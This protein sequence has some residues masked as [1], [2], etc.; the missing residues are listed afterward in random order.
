[1]GFIGFAGFHVILHF[2]QGY[3]R[4]DKIVIPGI[5]EKEFKQKTPKFVD[6]VVAGR[7]CVFSRFPGLSRGLGL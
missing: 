5:A 1:M 6:S 4:L 7:F 3:I 2:I